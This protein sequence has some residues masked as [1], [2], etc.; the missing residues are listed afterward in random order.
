[1]RRQ[2]IRHPWILAL[3]L[4][5]CEPALPDDLDSLIEMM[6]SNSETVAVAAANK[7]QRNFGKEGLL[8]ALRT[9]GTTARAS[10]PRWLTKF[11]DADVEQALIVVAANR[12]EDE[13]PRITAIWTLGD[14]GTRT[15]VPTL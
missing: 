8:R 11:P 7:V 1:M 2:L 12:N 9:G 5:S 13:S 6:N 15:S 4:I 3:T 10:A 14:I